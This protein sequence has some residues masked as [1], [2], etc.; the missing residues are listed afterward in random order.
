MLAGSDIGAGRGL[1]FINQ[2]VAFLNFVLG[3][4]YLVNVSQWKHGTM[5]LLKF[6][7]SVVSD[8]R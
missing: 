1:K 5:H 7:L 8:D 4:T 6:L 3:L 2:V